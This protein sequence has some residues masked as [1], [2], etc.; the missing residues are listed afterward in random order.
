MAPGHYRPIFRLALRPAGA[1]PSLV[2][3]LVNVAAAAV[4]GMLMGM[5]RI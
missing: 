3:V 5:K 1:L 4:M 2:E